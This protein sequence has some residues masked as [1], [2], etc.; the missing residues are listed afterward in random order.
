M[1][2]H[3][4]HNHN[5]FEIIFIHEGRGVHHLNGVDYPYSGKTLFLLGT[6]DYHSFT[7]EEETEFTFLKFTNIYLQGVNTVEVDRGWNE[8][9]D[10]LLASAGKHYEDI[11][12]SDEERA[13]LDK[14]IRLIVE[15][16]E[17]KKNENEET[18][19]F[20]VQTVMAVIKRNACRIDGMN[21]INKPEEK[22][23]AIVHYIHHHIH[24]TEEIQIDHLSDVFGSSRNYLGIYFKEQ[25]GITLREYV[26]QHRLKL[27]ENRLLHSSFSIKE[28]SFEFGFTDL[29]HFNKFFQKHK[30]VAPK[31]F[32]AHAL[33]ASA[34]IVGA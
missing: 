16:W 29:S 7:I 22:I 34:M 11:L 15:E 30:G 8:C 14:V 18:I 5:H 23:T 6:S 26:S 10:G 19:F 28:I 27:I 21:G 12:R 31:E 4:V 13:M 32:R 17:R 9:V 3:P 25:L 24:N 33:R 2:H 1:W 20:M